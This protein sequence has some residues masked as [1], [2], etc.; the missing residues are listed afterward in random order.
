MQGGGW[1]R[2]R[3]GRVV[4]AAVDVVIRF[5]RALCPAAHVGELHRRPHEDDYIMH[6]H[7]GKR[8]KETGRDQKRESGQHRLSSPAEMTAFLGIY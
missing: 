1:Q 5:H 3:V 6:I 7:L 4:G 8:A 2:G